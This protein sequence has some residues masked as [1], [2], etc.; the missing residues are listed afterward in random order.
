VAL[1]FNSIAE[2]WSKRNGIQIHLQPEAARLLAK[3]AL[4]SG[5]KLE[6]VFA[7]T[8]RDYEHGLNLIRRTQGIQQFEITADVV[9]DPRATLD[10]WI[11][12]YYISQ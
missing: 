10:Q 9:R 11:R 2:E 7:E 3:K 5:D 1:A 6:D 12:A 8:F 4:D